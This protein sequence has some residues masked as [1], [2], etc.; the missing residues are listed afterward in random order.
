MLIWPSHRFEKVGWAEKGSGTNSAHRKRGQ[1]PIV[2]S[3]I[4]RG[5]EPIVRSTL[6]AIWLLVPDPF[7][8]RAPFGPFGYWVLTPFPMQPSTLWAIWLV[9]PA[10]LFCPLEKPGTSRTSAGRRCNSLRPVLACGPKFCD[11]AYGSLRP[12]ART[13]TA[14]ILPGRFA[15]RSLR[16]KHA[17]D[18]DSTGHR[19]TAIGV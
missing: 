12:D 5:Q 16:G 14:I 3:G 8:C 9:V 7:L 10:P 17:Q 19:P 18:S 11:A 1:D 15:A 6:R 4:K 2:R 13:D